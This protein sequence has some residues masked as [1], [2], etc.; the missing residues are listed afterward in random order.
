VI[1]DVAF[2]PD[3]RRLAVAGNDDSVTVWDV[4]T[5]TRVGEPLRPRPGFPAS[6]PAFSPDGK[7]LAIAD[8][9]GLLTLWD[10]ASRSMIWKVRADR[11]FVAMAA[12]SPDGRTIATGGLEGNLRLWDASTGAALGANQVAQRGFL[13]GVSYSP[14]GRLLAASGTDGT[15]TLWDVR[16]RKQVGTPLP[17]GSPNV[18][19]LARFSP[20]GGMLAST[21]LD[22]TVVLWDVD[23]AHWRARAC[24][25]AGRDL[26]RQEWAEFLPGRPYRAVCSG[27]V[28]AGR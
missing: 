2:S 25:V 10:V 15:V 27:S 4:A 3:G 13:L 18:S 24:A 11:G 16:S 8:E 6:S 28:A 12:F 23:P 22:G 26:T 1:S 21:S 20:A 19:A 14:D 5:R 9:A 17:V 7:T